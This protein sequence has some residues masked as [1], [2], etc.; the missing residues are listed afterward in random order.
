V[1]GAIVQYLCDHYGE[2][3]LQPKPGS[4]AALKH[5]QLMHFAEGSAMIPLL[6]RIYVSRLGEGGAPLH[7]RI[8][9][10]VVSYFDYLESILQPSGYFIGDDL[11]AADIMLSFPVILATQQPEGKR[12]PKLCAFVESIKARPAWQRAMGVTEG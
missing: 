5:L 4:P 2:G 6:L 3:R 9:D 10:Q 11:T 12:W 7:E 1:L 8:D